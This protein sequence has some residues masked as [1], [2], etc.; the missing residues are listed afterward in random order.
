[1]AFVFR[2]DLISSISPDKQVSDVG[3]GQYIP[4]TETRIN[5]KSKV[6]FLSGSKRTGI[7]QRTKIESD[8]P[9]P[10][11]YYHD[12]MF[13]NFY[14]NMQKDKQNYNQKVSNIKAIN[15]LQS[16][17]TTEG[18]STVIS[19]GKNAESLGFLGKDI[20][21]K[22]TNDKEIITPGPGHYIKSKDR[23]HSVNMRKK[24]AFTVNRVF[25]KDEEN[26]N[27][28]SNKVI[29]IP[30][31]NQAYGYELDEDRKIILNDDPENYKRFKGEK[32]DTVGPGNYNVDA[33]NVW[34]KKGVNIKH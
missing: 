15:K 9:G 7:S 26:I 21:F 28:K 20:R 31:K 6:P 1:M 22:V 30:G 32:N 25:N 33:E 27:L 4:Q 2:A 18:F 23:L 19:N 17:T 24:S 14:K 12:E 8:F 5:K 16:L 34:F 10:G 3:P 29:S 11:A 13:E